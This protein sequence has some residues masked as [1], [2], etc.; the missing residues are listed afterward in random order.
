MKRR[1]NNRFCKREE[2]Q[3]IQ[4]THNKVSLLY[5]GGLGSLIRKINY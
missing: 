4:S 5:L 2:N 1:K 3:I